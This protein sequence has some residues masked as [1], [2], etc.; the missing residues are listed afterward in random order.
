MFPFLFLSFIILSTIKIESSAICQKKISGDNDNH[1]LCWPGYMPSK[2]QKV[3]NIYK[4]TVV[5]LE[6]ILTGVTSHIKPG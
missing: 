3:K 6:N 4:K 1:V 5:D 2:D